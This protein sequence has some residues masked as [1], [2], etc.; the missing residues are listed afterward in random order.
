MHPAPGA[1]GRPSFTA[2]VSSVDS[3][4]A[5]YVAMTR[6]QKGRKEII[7]D[8]EEM[9]KVGFNLKTEA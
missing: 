3:T 4:T 7:S 2:L 5:K 9:C 1:E 8:L 6:V